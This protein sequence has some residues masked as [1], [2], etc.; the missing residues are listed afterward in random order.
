MIVRDG[1][2]GGSVVECRIL[3]DDAVGDNNQYFLLTFN[4][5]YFIDDCVFL[6]CTKGNTT[7]QTTNLIMRF[8][9]STQLHRFFV[10]CVFLV[11]PT[12]SQQTC[13]NRRN[14]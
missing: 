4:K 8:F 13:L 5:I 6:F 2:G 3:H 7:T 1:G 11:H 9:S 12:F 10:A 14:L